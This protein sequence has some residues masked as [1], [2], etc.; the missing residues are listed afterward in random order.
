MKAGRDHLVPPLF[1]FFCPC[2]LENKR[3]FQFFN[4]P[5]RE[6]LGLDYRCFG[7]SYRLTIFLLDGNGIDKIFS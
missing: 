6:A 2:L 4:C 5:D 3:T 1:C 7:S